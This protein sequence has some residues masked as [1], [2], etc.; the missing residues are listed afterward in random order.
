MIFWKTSEVA[1]EEARLADLRKLY[2]EGKL[3]TAEYVDAMNKL[4]QTGADAPASSTPNV[5]DLVQLG[6]IAVVIGAVVY[7]IKT[8]KG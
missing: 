4:K 6:L 2:D 5:L 7:G 3:T 8:F 1:Q